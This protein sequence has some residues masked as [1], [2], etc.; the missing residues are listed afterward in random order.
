MV[1]RLP[2][3]VLPLDVWPEPDQ[4]A[5]RTAITP[6]SIFDARQS[7]DNRP[8]EQ[9]SALR[10]AWGRW[11][12]YLQCQGIDITVGG[13]G[14]LERKTVAQHVDLLLQHLG[15]VTVRSYMTSLLSVADHMF[16]PNKLIH[17]KT[18]T[19]RVQKEIS[20]VG[21]QPPERIDSVTMDKITDLML[22]DISRI[23]NTYKRAGLYRDALALKILI[24][25]PLRIGNLGSL[26]IGKEITKVGAQYRITIPGQAAK[27]RRPLTYPVPASLT[28][29]IDTYLDV[30]RPRLLE[31][32]GMHWQDN[33]ENA[34][35][36]SR[37]GSAQS[38]KTLSRH[39]GDLTEQ[40]LGE[41][42]TP[43]RLRRIAATSIAVMAPDKVN[44]IK[45]LLGQ[46]TPAMGEKHYNRAG[47]IEAG[48]KFQAIFNN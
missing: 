32:R 30:H 35:W 2:W 31:C 22:D 14:Y 1:Q 48:I 21:D 28:P 20:P 7:L 36:I 5:W 37:D 4:A 10:A 43:H 23:S 40:Y 15:R 41:R 33:A 45:S 44:L 25:T 12:G 13:E 8:P 38:P 26:R 18:V 19:R 3:S 9:I 24:F 47:T 46:S 11:L 39:I 42:V 16:S 34:F 27:A 29:L 17:L 6:A